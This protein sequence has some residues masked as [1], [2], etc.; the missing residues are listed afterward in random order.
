MLWVTRSRGR[1]T[2]QVIGEPED[3][4]GAKQLAEDD[5]FQFQCWALGLVG[6]RPVEKKKGA[7]RGIDGR[8]YFH[9]EPDSPET[10]TKQIIF[11]VKSGLPVQRTFE[12]CEA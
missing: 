1:Q 11:S 4:F 10:K 2:Y 7:D 8:L 5:P 9:D 3:L 6:A 12:T